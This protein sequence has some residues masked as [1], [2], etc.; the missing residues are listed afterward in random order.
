MRHSIVDAPAGRIRG[1]GADVAN[2]FLG[3]PYAA[4]PVGDD[5]WRAPRPA[6]PLGHEF[7][8]TAYGSDAAQKPFPP[9]AAPLR[10]DP[11]EDCLYLNV[12]QPL[13][14]T[15]TSQHAVMVW[16]H[17]GGFVNGGTSPAVYTGRRFARDGI[18]FVSMNYRLGRFGF[19]AHPALVDEGF[20]ANFGLLDQIAALRWVHENIAAFGGDPARVTVFGE[21]AGGMSVHALLQAPSARGLFQQAIIQ[22]GG[23]RRRADGF[24]TLAQAAAVGAGF[25]PGLDAGALRAMS[26]DEVIADLNLMTMGSPGFAGTMTDGV[27]VLGETLDAVDA[28]LYADVPLIVGANSADGFQFPTDKDALFANFGES[29]AEARTVYDPDGSTPALAVA[30]ATSADAM[31]IEPARAVANALAEKQPVWTYRFDYALPEWR[32]AMGGAPHASEIPYVFDTVD[33]R[34]GLNMPTTRLDEEQPVADITHRYWV[35]FAKTGRPDGGGGPRWPTVDQSRGYVQMI[36][37]DGARNVSDPFE[38]RL[39]FAERVA[40]KRS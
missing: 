37:E 11:S 10:T 25:A 13:D 15:P 4:P 27:T 8:A 20:G 12:W 23:G 21:S 19:F 40:Q 36:D 32:E 18:V 1:L 30:T 2:A 24:P 9:D 35:D 5:R 28:G 17:G 33:L 22:S 14:A 29:E 34:H 3:I 38:A 6:G 26:S 7:E 39:D 16:I 31:M